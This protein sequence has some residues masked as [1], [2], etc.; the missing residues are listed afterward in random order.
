MVK[1]MSL[2]LVDDVTE[3]VLRGFH[4]GGGRAANMA[5]A[6]VCVVRAACTTGETQR[7]DVEAVES[8]EVRSWFICGFRDYMY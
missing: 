5:A 3:P 1:Y 8:L 7:T 6:Q 4:G 2:V